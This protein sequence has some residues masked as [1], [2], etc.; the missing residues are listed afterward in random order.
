MCY[1]C[2]LGNWE[3]TGEEVFLGIKGNRGCI[4]RHCV[5][6]GPLLCRKCKRDQRGMWLSESALE[7]GEKRTS[8]AEAKAGKACSESASTE[9]S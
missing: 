2:A 6:S 1:D 5:T 7:F 9:A 8:K 3:V 4:T